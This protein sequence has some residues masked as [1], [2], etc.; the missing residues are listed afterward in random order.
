MLRLALGLLLLVVYSVPSKATPNTDDR[1]FDSGRR[2]STPA[3]KHRHASRHRATRHA[4]VARSAP[5]AKERHIRYRR[6]VWKH[7]R[8]SLGQPVEGWTSVTTRE[9][10]VVGGRPAG[11]PHAFCGCGASLRIFGRI[12]PM[13]NLAANWLHFPRAQA[14]PGMVAVRHHHVFVLERHL[15][16]NVW[17]AHDS[18]S[19]RHLTRVHPRSISG[20]AIVN[21]RSG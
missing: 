12:I 6:I 1:Y 3:T 13:L 20:Y 14:A 11:C 4:R 19:G 17:M 16:G 18:N 8:A 15:G 21:P 7:T 10:A 2:V 5:K 9:N